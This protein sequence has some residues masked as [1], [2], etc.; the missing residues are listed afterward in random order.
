MEHIHYKRIH[1]YSYDE[2]SAPGFSWKAIR[3]DNS[4]FEELEENK[5]IFN[6]LTI[7][8]VGSSALSDLYQQ[9]RAEGVP[10]CQGTLGDFSA[11]IYKVDPQ[12]SAF[13]RDKITHIKGGENAQAFQELINSW[14]TSGNAKNVK[15][16]A[17]C[18]H[19]Y[20]Y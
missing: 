8:R 12:T 5:R 15:R 3:S 11:D 2:C 7:Q 20:Y 14:L 16:L 19:G 10:E 18:F 1:L 6:D 17:I 9:L 13:I 4:E